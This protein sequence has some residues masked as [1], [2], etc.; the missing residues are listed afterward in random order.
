MSEQTFLN[1]YHRGVGHVVDGVVA[2]CDSLL[3][4]T[5]QLLLPLACYASISLVDARRSISDHSQVVV[6]QPDEL[7][8]VADCCCRSLGL[9][10]SGILPLGSCFCSRRHPSARICRGAPAAPAL[11]PCLSCD[12]LSVPRCR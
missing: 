7:V 6:V 8:D 1:K 2:S 3:P 11:R 9:V 12:V 4:H 10:G 5:D